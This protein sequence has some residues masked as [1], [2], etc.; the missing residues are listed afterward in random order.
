MK[1]QSRVPV[2]NQTA[3][4]ALREA[5]HSLR[6]RSPFALLEDVFLIAESQ[7]SFTGTIQ[8]SFQ[9]ILQMSDLS[10]EKLEPLERSRI[11]SVK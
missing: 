1:K 6:G 11:T 5:F 3:E 4:D 8:D 7:F 2:I 9:I 10:I